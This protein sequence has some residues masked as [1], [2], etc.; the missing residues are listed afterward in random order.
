MLKQNERRAIPRTAL[1]SF[2]RDRLELRFIEPRPGSFFAGAK[3]FF[4]REFTLLS[5][6]EG[7]DQN[8][9]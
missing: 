2:A 9:Y 5:F 3:R 8:A 6:I 7:I 4:S 1:G